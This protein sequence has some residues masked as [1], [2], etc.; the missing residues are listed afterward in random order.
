M[1]LKIAA[2]CHYF[3]V[4]DKQLSFVIKD[5]SSFFVTLDQTYVA[6]SSYVI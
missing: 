3:N 2:L 1:Q 4:S 6:D 5:N